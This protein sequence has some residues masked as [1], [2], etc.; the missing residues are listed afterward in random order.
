MEIALNT[1][2]VAGKINN[3]EIHQTGK[4]KHPP[5]TGNKKIMPTSQP[6]GL[7]RATIQQKVRISAALGQVIVKQAAGNGVAN[8]VPSLPAP[9]HQANH[10][11]RVLF[12]L[13]NAQ[14]LQGDSSVQKLLDNLRN[15]QINKQA[16]ANVSAALAAEINQAASAAEK[17]TTAYQQAEEQ[18][19]AAGEDQAAKQQAVDDAQAELE[20]MNPDDANY[21]QI[22]QKL[23]EANT[24]LDEA[25]K[26]TQQAGVQADTAKHVA[27]TAQGHYASVLQ[28]SQYQNHNAVLP[29]LF[30]NTQKKSDKSSAGTMAR[31]I[32][33][34][35]QL[36]GD[37]SVNK[38]KADL[39]TSNKLQATRQKEMQKKSEEYQE[40]VRRAEE[41]SK[42]TGCLADILGG[43]A[44]LV[45]AITSVF[46]GAGVGLMAVGIGLMAADG[47][48]EAITG[49]SLTSM[50][51]D[52]LMKYVLNP[53]MDVIGKII[54]EVFDKTPLGLLLNAID[55]ATGSN[56]MDTI[57]SVVTAVAAVA[58]M[59]A[60]AFVAK[61]AAKFMMKNMNELLTKIIGQSV[62]Q[63]L[64]QAIKKMMPQIVKTASNQLS[65]GFASVKNALADK[66]AD[67]PATLQARLL[68]LEQLRQFTTLAAAG[69]QT[70]G[71]ILVGNLQAETSEILASMTINETAIKLSREQNEHILE[72]F[73]REQE[74]LTSMTKNMSEAL[75]KQQETGRAILRHITA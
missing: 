55:K 19:K 67:D 48:T 39:E 8:D 62:K 24:A 56:M 70:T 37:L 9:A 36:M 40:K 74:M 73:K 28:E 4:E 10:T 21:A 69:S 47:I 34:C 5:S 29:D 18:L 71:N 61:S 44:T 49:K 31:I 22:Q 52:P 38:L 68:Q 75:M 65:K 25:K 17:A 35:I 2:R 53:L 50:V 13:A 63:A 16:L 15:L 11:S 26:A 57:H 7:L 30:S 51:M 41:T 42:I 32:A 23:K 60:I 12:F 1:M 45:G 46:G 72:Y 33:E 58:V 43:L 64:Q 3:S 14:K 27:E 59:V 54:T 20:G 6:Q 66:L